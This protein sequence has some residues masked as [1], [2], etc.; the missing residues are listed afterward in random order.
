M[1]NKIIAILDKIV[2]NE[3]LNRAEKAVLDKVL[4]PATDKKE[5]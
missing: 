4:P 1:L 5:E 3:Q 2:D